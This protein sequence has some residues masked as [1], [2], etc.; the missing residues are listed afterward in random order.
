MTTFSSARRGRPVPETMLDS[1]IWVFES[2]HDEHFIM[3]E[4]QHH[5][6]K[7]LYF[8]EGRG[9]V[10]ADWPGESPQSVNCVSGDCLLIPIQLRHRIVDHPAHPVSLYGLAV[11]PQRIAGVGEI[12][13]LL[14]SGK[15]SAQ[16]AWQLGIEQRLRKLLYLVAQPSPAYRIAAV[17]GAMDVFAQLAMAE[18][19]SHFGDTAAA[20]DQLDDGRTGAI[21]EYLR[22]L[23]SNFFEPVTIDHAAQI[24]RMSR[25]KFTADFRQRTGGTWLAYV[26][27]LRISHAIGLLRESDSKVA[28][29]AFQSGFE[30]VSTF[31][32]TLR[33]LTGKR[34]LD[35]RTEMGNS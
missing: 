32:R 28:S 13:P 7:L 6:P 20:S 24:C 14:P 29:I 18:Q 22:W 11:D 16:R 3:A 33:R 4:T 23:H 17:A 30:D 35:Y 31:Y 2:R 1:G 8:R 5:F 27:E 34:P 25:R 12:E 26:H 19:P 9:E 15:L 21:D 10:I